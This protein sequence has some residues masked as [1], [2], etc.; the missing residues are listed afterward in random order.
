MNKGTVI[1]FARLSRTPDRSR[2][3]LSLLSQRYA[4]ENY[5][6]RK[7]LSIF[8]AYESIGSAYRTDQDD[9]KKLLRSCRGKTLIVYEA[10][11]LSRNLENFAAI[12]AICV[13]N[14]HAITVAN[15][16]RTFSPEVAG[17][18]E[19]LYE[20]IKIA[21]KESR[22]I[23]ERVSRTAKY[24]KSMETEWGMM[25]NELGDIVENPHEQKISKLIKLLG[26]RGSSIAEITQL[27]GEV[28]KL[29]GKDP[30]EIMD[31]DVDGT[32]K[33]VGRLLPFEM[34]VD[35]IAET[36]K[37][38]EIRKRRAKWSA[39]DILKELRERK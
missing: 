8:C 9:L 21:E 27:V 20:L 24:K 23:G 13:R 5:M 16:E 38:Y 10:N 33:P 39:K 32:E 18:Y 28:G 3:I 34:S 17:D 36:F 30:F 6:S 14:K 19:A 37:I 12:W 29:E 31:C 25:R 15:I 4:I 22:D 1:V 26:T 2:G 7:G 35:D 11:R